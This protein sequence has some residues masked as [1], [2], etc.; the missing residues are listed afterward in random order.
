MT[1]PNTNQPKGDQ[2]QLQTAQTAI[3]ANIPAKS[4]VMVG[5]V[6]YTQAQ[7]LAYI[8]SLLAPILAAQAAKQAFTA[9]AETKAQN[10]PTTHTFLVELHAAMVTLFGRS[11]PIL[12]QFGYTPYKAK[13]KKSAG[14]TVVTTAKVKATKLKLGTKTPSQKAA[15]LASPTPA[16]AVSND[17]TVTLVGA[18]SSAPASAADNT[19]GSAGSTSSNGANGVSTPASTAGSSTPPSGS[20][21]A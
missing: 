8:T 20:S 12:V 4:T 6:S 5:G 10:G 13:A 17:G 15:L 9:A 11:S 21:Q 3:S 1:T 14:E 18:G 7:L 2:L 16:F 19:S